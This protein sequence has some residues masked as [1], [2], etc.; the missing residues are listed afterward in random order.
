[1]ELVRKGCAFGTPLTAVRLRFESVDSKP[2][3]RIPFDTFGLT[4][5]FVDVTSVWNA[6]DGRKCVYQA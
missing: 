4:S 1:M 3:T 5:R 2:R 6:I